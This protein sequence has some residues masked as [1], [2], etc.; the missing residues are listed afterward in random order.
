M[1]ALVTYD[2]LGIIVL[3]VLLEL[4]YDRTCYNYHQNWMTTMSK[5]DIKSAE[6]DENY[7]G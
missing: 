7:D 4:I 1:S 6:L 3:R 5:S 2:F